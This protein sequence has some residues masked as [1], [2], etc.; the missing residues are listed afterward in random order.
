VPYVVTVDISGDY[1]R[2]ASGADYWGK[3]HD[4]FDPRFAVAVEQSLRDTAQQHR[5]DP[6]CLGYFID[7]EISWGGGADDKNHFGLVYGTLAG[8]ADQPAKMAM[9]ENLKQRH[10]SIQRL[11]EAWR[12]RFASWDALLQQAIRP[13]APLP[14]AMKEDFSAFLTTFAR[15]YFRVVRD[16]LGRHDPNH[17]YLGCR[18]A[19]RT[20][21]AVQ[22]AAEFVDVVSFNI[23]RPLVDPREWDF[24]R[25][26]GKPCII[27]EFHFG[28]VDRGMFHTGLV[29][30]A[31]QEDRAARYQAYVRSVVDHPAFVGCHWFQYFD[32]PVTGRS[33]DGENYNIGLV[34][35]TDTPYPEMVAAAKAVH[36]EIYTRRAGR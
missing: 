26:L 17:L 1:A 21:E 8:S 34:D 13:A 11:N 14:P 16:A 35:V 15:Q 10:G 30:A 25:T 4:P 27:G 29:A 23:Y 20:P 18:F 28:A 32:E 19:W 24:T 33:Y 7:N 31:S 6:W 22:A 2:V 3:M 12:T 5:D 9:V 36:Q